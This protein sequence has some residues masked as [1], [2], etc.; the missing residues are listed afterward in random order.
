MFKNK[1]LEA[2]IEELEASKLKLEGDLQ[3]QS[4]EQLEAVNAKLTEASEKLVTAEASIATLTGEAEVKDTKITELEASQEDFDKKVD[5]AVTAEVAKLGEVEPIKGSASTGKDNV[6]LNAEY[7]QLAP[8][9][10]RADF[11]KKNPD[12]KLT[13][14]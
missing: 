7:K 6:E 5:A 4:S 3:S 8:G 2:K 10:E 1:E 12:F 9:A 11:R 14:K 13:Q